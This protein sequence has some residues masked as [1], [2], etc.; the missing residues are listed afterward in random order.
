MVSP[1]C[2]YSA[3]EL[4]AFPGH[5]NFNVITVSETETKSNRE[6]SILVVRCKDDYIFRK[7]QLIYIFIK[8][9]AAVCVCVCTVCVERVCEL[10]R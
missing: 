7:E 8:L 5:K 6:L 2:V 4:C 9:C 1:L 3:L 10:E